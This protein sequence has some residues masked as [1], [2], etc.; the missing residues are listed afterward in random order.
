VPFTGRCPA[1]WQ[2]GH[3]SADSGD[4]VIDISGSRHPGPV[5]GLAVDGLY[6]DLVRISWNAYAG[7]VG[8]RVHLYE[9]TGTYQ[10][11]FL[12]T[13]P[14]GATDH[15]QDISGDGPEG[16]SHCFALRVSDAYGY[17]A[18]T[19]ACGAALG[20]AGPPP[21]GGDLDPA[22]DPDPPDSDPGGSGSGG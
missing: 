8:A 14:P 20:P 13:L 21:G 10:D 16:A 3:L 22:P 7:P 15:I 4:Y 17:S 2:R 6:D 9:G 12:L 18:P 5:T 11:R 19:V 1:P